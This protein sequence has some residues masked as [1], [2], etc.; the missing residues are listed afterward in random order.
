M[1]KDKEHK[2]VKLQLE[3]E[4]ISYE[5]RPPL[6][7][8]NNVNLTNISKPV[9]SSSP[10]KSVRSRH[11][12]YRAKS[13]SQENLTDLEAKL[14][15]TG[16]Q[17]KATLFDYLRSEMRR[18]YLLEN[19]GQRFTEKREKFYIF[20]T[21]PKELEQFIWY[22]FFQCVD[23][24]LFI[25]TLLPFRFALAIWFLFSRS[26]RRTLNAFLA[27]SKSKTFV[28]VQPLLQPAEICDLLKGTTQIEKIENDRLSL[29][30]P[31]QTNPPLLFQ[32]SF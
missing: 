7:N 32:V 22:G 1:E 16:K 18:G 19:D 12:S 31:H 30:V 5:N 9:M 15:S 17:Y 6:A 24:F 21:I 4:F 8:L 2:R 10:I 3:K 23:A 26:I 27:Q 20:L 14:P 25:F 11:N 13:L 29:P 28:N